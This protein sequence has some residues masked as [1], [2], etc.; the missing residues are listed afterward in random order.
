MTIQLLR[1]YQ[2][3]TPGAVINTFGRGVCEELIRRGIAKIV[4]PSTV[5]QKDHSD[6][7][8]RNSTNRRTRHAR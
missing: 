1:Q 3:H 5:I 4:N 2:T 8:N 7:S 6:S